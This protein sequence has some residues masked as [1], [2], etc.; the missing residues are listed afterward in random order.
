MLLVTELRRAVLLTHGVV[1]RVEVGRTLEVLQLLVLL[2]LTVVVLV[3]VV[4]LV[5]VGQLS[6][7]NG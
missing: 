3:L 1:V 6:F 5:V 7:C 2:A 4:V